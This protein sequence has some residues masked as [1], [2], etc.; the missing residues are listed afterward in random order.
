MVEFLASVL[1]FLALAPSL[2]EMP[3]RGQFRL[4]RHRHKQPTRIWKLVNRWVK[5]RSHD[6]DIV[7]QTFELLARSLRAGASVYT[8]VNT[9]AVDF[10]ESDLPLIVDRIRRGSD[11]EEALDY[12]ARGNA[13][14]QAM[15]AL[16]VLGNK[17]GAAI[18]A[19][20]DRAAASI[21]L[22]QSLSDEIKAL[23]AQTRIS[24]IV[25]AAAPVG[26]GVIL[27]L[28]DYEVLLVLITTP[29]GLVALLLGILL[30][31]LGMWWMNKLVKNV[32]VW[33]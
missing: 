28:V 24:G 33:E 6:R 21:R 9:V 3:A 10:P 2:V 5:S 22:R 7:P 32:S 20:L 26:F 11:M 1:L 19:S 30:Q 12:W 18:A 14:R 25:V 8:A 16:L 23:T 15:A 13:D 27:A 29:V 31:L 4:G 17:S